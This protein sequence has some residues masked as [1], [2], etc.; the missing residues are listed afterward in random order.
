VLYVDGEMP[1]AMMQERLR[2]MAVSEDSKLPAPDYFRLVTPDLQ[3]GPIPDLSTPEGRAILKDLS[4]DS[5][6]IIIDNLSCLFRSGVE[7]EAESWQPVQDWALE[8]RRNG[9]TIIFVHHAAKGGQ[10]R[11]TSKREDILDVVITLKQPQG[12]RADQGACFEVSFEKTRHFAGSDAAPFK[13]QLVEQTDGLWN[14]EIGETSSD[15]DLEVTA[16]AKAAN[17]GLT[18][19]EIRQR[20]GLTK[21]QVETRKDKPKKRG[22]IKE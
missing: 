1:A 7:N 13:V 19:Q 21:S 3:D 5:E 18:I 8:M 11:G 22:L 2:R 17:E 12:H 20:T 15:E 10:Q 14:W 4:E 6:L 16:V 9:K